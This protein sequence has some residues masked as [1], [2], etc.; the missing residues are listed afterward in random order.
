MIDAD[1]VNLA[2]VVAAELRAQMVPNKRLYRT[3]NM[4]RSVSVVEIDERNIDVVIATDYASF[5]NTRG[6]FA[7]WVQD[8]TASAIRAYCSAQNVD[9]LTA[10]GIADP[11]FV[12][13]G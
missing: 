9:D 6:R 8:T 5:T 12:Y 7:G 4:K 2:T 11:Q 13:G 3:G 10:F 1:L